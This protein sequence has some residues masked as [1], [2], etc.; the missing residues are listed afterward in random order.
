MQTG[1]PNAPAIGTTLWTDEHGM[2]EAVE[3]LEYGLSELHKGEAPYRRFVEADS[4]NPSEVRYYTARLV[5]CWEDGLRS[6]ANYVSENEA[7]LE[8]F[9]LQGD[10]DP[11]FLSLIDR[12]LEAKASALA[13][14]KAK[15][16]K[17]PAYA[18]VTTIP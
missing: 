9:R 14:G 1:V 18:Y 2:L 5:L 6:E 3:V 7:L 16:G 12:E 11:P 8:L 17:P 13:A 15:M 10:G 4:R